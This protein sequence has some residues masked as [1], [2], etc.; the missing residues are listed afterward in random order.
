MHDIEE[1][2]NAD[3]NTYIY[4]PYTKK[5]RP[6]Y[7]KI[8]NENLYLLCYGI[9]SVMYLAMYNR[10]I[11][12]LENNFIVVDD[13]NEGDIFTWSTI[14]PNNYIVT[15]QSITKT[16]YLLSKIDYDSQKFIEILYKIRFGQ[17]PN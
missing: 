12:N 2:Y 15:V 6:L 5:V 10:Q 9:K 1:G 4:T 14:F 13:S 11:D 3:E 17:L 16:Y 7:K 8:I